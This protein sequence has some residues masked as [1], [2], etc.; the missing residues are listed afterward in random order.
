MTA[1]T[2]V[3]RS[4]QAKRCQTWHSPMPCSTAA[5]SNALST[6]SGDKGRK[7]VAALLVPMHLRK[8]AA[9]N[10]HG[11]LM[12]TRTRTSCSTEVYSLC[13]I[14]IVK[15]LLQLS[16]KTKKS[17]MLHW[18]EQLRCTTCLSVLY[19]TLPTTASA[20]SNNSWFSLCWNLKFKLQLNLALQDK[21]FRFGVSEAP[22][23]W[24]F[25]RCVY[26][27]YYLLKSQNIPP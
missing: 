21:T 20:N 15:S 5:C 11:S 13:Q 9:G 27:A 16:S 4:K 18:T 25:D 22:I 26:V 1:M 10:N 2:C 3:Q 23:C 6:Q 14:K 17:G 12:L 7:A 8:P 24:A 19:L